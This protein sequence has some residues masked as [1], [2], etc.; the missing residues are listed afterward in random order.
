MRRNN[1]IE[2][3]FGIFAVRKIGM[4]G[5]RC[6]GYGFLFPKEVFIASL[7]TSHPS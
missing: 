5:A 7:V 1:D 3:S 6:G 4:A 2:F